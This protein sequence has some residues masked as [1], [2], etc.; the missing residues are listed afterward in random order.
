MRDHANGVCREGGPSRRVPRRE[1]EEASRCAGA[2]GSY[3]RLSARHQSSA[4][5][6][7]GAHHAHVG[8]L[9]VRAAVIAALPD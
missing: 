5:V 9:P 1:Q 7:V 2:D 6:E 8:V 4:L 3:Y